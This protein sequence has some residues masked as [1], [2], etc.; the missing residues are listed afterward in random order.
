MKF[1]D[2]FA[3]QKSFSLAMDIFEVSKSF[4]KEE[5]FSLTD[6]VRRSSRAV[7]VA[8]AESYGKRK[9]PKHFISKLTDSDSENLE[10]QAW[11]KFALAC[12][13]ITEVEHNELII[14]SE[15]VGRLLNYMMNNPEKFGV[16]S[17]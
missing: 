5:K 10:T 15:E 6:Q 1:Q 9:Y 4:P 14:K 7:S 12:E 11:L 8:I 2:L 3:F 13:Y 16:A 17:N